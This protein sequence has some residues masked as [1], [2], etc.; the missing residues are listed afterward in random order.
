MVVGT[1]ARKGGRVYEYACR[2]CRYQ[3]T[4]PNIKRVDREVVH[5]AVLAGMEHVLPSGRVEEFIQLTERD[6]VLEVAKRIARERQD[7]ERRLKRWADKYE[8]RDDLAWA[9]VE[10][11]KEKLK[12]LPSAIGPV[13]RLE[14]SVVENRLLQPAGDRGSRVHGP[15]SAPRVASRELRRA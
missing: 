14:P 5:E 9:R 13:P 2:T 11:I 6:D 10:E 4:C 1:S 7:L 15:P 8:Q 3:G 12:A